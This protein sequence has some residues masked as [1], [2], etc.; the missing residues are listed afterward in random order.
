[1]VRIYLQDGND[2][3]ETRGRKGGRIAIRVIGGPGN[4]VVDDSH[5]RGV[6]FYDSE[7]AN[8]IEGGHG[9]SLQ[10]KSFA[11]KGREDEVPQV[12]P[13]DWGRFTKPLL[14]AGYH[15][16]PG[17]ILGAG[18]DTKAYGF[19]KDPWSSRHVLT[20]GLA[21]AVQRGFLNYE[22]DYR[23]ENSWLHGALH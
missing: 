11:I 4:E 9:T 10:A 1:E 8:R 14:T 17:L 13:R 2:H 20:G 21:T 18:F 7:G 15:P 6:D 12:P 19:R 16:D 22:G 5:G 3:V 23:R